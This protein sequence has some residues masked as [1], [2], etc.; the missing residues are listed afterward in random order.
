MVCALQMNGLCTPVLKAIPPYQDA[1]KKSGY[2]YKLE[3]KPTPKDK[4][5]GCFVWMADN[6]EFLK[7]AEVAFF[8]PV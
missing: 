2:N 3:Y 8:C 5:K 7:Q 4:A 1:L 6:E